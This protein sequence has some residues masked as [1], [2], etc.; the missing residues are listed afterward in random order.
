MRDE[1]AQ[2]EMELMNSVLFVSEFEI[3]EERHLVREIHAV[4]YKGLEIGSEDQNTYIAGSKRLSYKSQSKTFP[5]F[6]PI[7]LEHTG[8]ERLHLASQ[9]EGKAGTSAENSAL[10][11]HP[12]AW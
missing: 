2:V 3:P 5:E 10:K 12:S 7:Y 9:H 4:G 11:L 8:D 1:G 6:R